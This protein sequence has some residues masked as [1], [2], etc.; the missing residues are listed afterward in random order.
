M[1]GCFG[2]VTCLVVFVPSESVSESETGRTRCTLVVTG[3]AR[4]DRL[5]SGKITLNAR[6]IAFPVLI[7]TY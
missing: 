3:A 6:H 5:S 4:D 7:F 1:Y 2:Y